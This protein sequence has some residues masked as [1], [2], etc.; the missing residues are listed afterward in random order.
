[1][2]W[3]R[4][5]ARTKTQV[6]AQS[7]SSVL[8]SVR[9]PRDAVDAQEPDVGSAGLDRAPADGL[10]V[11]VRDEAAGGVR[12]GMSAFGLP[13]EPVGAHPGRKRGK[14]LLR[15][16]LVSLALAG[17]RA[18][19]RSEHRLEVLPRGLVGRND[20]DL[21]RRAA[22]HA[23]TVLHLR[24]LSGGRIACERRAVR[25]RCRRP[26]VLRSRLSPSLARCCGPVV[27]AVAV[28]EL[29]QN[30]HRPTWVTR[31]DSRYRCR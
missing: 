29:A 28:R 30:C 16:Q 25:R 26:R 14:R 6:T 18:A 7:V 12:L 9:P 13:A 1:M 19:A 3:P 5:P 22:G 20:R 23:A 21:A 10:G 27:V 24:R 31:R 15:S 11:G 4:K 17:A 8:S 2:P